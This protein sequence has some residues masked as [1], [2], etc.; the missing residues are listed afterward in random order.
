M[1]SFENFKAEDGSPLYS[2]ILQYI[3]RGV[4]AGVI[5]DGDALP[6]RRI[7][8]ATLG[9]NPNTVQRAYRELEEEGL[10]T[11]HA[12]AKSVMVLEEATKKR[13]REE[14]VESDV[15]TF[16]KSLKAAGVTKEEAQNLLSRLWDEDNV[17]V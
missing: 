13:I 17:E 7:L 9:I 6:S 5:Q 3:K 16:T 12:G 1:I 10:V 15:R 4:A 14:L 2:Q 11:N 8:S